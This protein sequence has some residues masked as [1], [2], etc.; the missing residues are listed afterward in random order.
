L[1]ISAA[2]S[3]S[4]DENFEELT[5]VSSFGTCLIVVLI[6]NGDVLVDS[7]AHILDSV[8]ILFLSSEDSESL[9][10]N[11]EGFAVFLSKDLV[12][13]L[14]IFFE[15]DDFVEKLFFIFLGS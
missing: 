8:I 1:L 7:S 3:E 11:A 12:K 10:E 4:L 2:D 15:G 14:A 9:D 13:S 5:A 6:N